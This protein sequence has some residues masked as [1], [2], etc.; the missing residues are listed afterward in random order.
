MTF[1]YMFFALRRSR[2]TTS[3]FAKNLQVKNGREVAPPTFLFR[4]KSASRHF[5]LHT[6]SFFALN[7]VARG[8]GYCLKRNPMCF[9]ALQK[10]S[11]MEAR[12][13]IRPPMTQLQRFIPFPNAIR[14][15]VSSTIA[16]ILLYTPSIPI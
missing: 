14:S 11:H 10:G 1:C 8:Q 12:E 9:F 4:R 3:F 13:R 6:I 15:L 5:W 16:S 2:H 7:R